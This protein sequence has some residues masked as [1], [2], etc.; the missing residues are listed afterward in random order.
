[1]RR[2][3][4]LGVS[5]W[6]AVGILV[7]WAFIAIFG[8]LISPHAPSAMIAERPFGRPGVEGLLGSDSLNRDV[9]SRLILGARITLGLALAT[10]AMSF[11]VG[12]PLGFAA[13][14][15]GGFV[16]DFLSRAVDVVLAFPAIILTLI[17]ISAVGS[18]A[19]TLVLTV[20]FIESMRAFRVARA[21]ALDVSVMDFVEVARARGESTT[22][23]LAND[24]LPNVAAPLAADFGIRFIFV[25]LTVSAVSFLG[26]GIQPPAIDW[27]GMVRENM[28]GIHFMAAATLLPAFCIFS[29][30]LSV[31]LLIDWDQSRNNRRIPTEI[32][33]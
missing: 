24:I 21:L 25:I 20:G 1:M 32:T 22:W 4:K 6:A 10:C 5:G 16:D 15:R 27:G 28:A 3:L 7:F 26:L 30:T 29:V 13:A 12:V 31:N 2:R 14:L 9:A 8:P 19:L 18:S 33:E 11:V 17:V 23:I